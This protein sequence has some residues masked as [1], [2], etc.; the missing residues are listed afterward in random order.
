MQ[1]KTKPYPSRPNNPQAGDMAL[2]LFECRCKDFH[3]K[4]T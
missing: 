4:K 3:D 2:Y 1:Y